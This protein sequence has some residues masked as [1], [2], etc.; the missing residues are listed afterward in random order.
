MRIHRL[1]WTQYYWQKLKYPRRDVPLTEVGQTQETEFPWRVGECRVYRLP[2]SKHAVAIGRWYGVQPTETE[3]GEQVLR[4]RPLHDW[5][6][7]VR[8]EED[9]AS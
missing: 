9:T 7:Y 1:L 3:D 5:R 6:A 8:E 2:F 4:L